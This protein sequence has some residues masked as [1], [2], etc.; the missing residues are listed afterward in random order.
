[1]KIDP[2][3]AA[4][5]IPAVLKDSGATEYEAVPGMT[6]RAYLA[7]TAGDPPVEWLENVMNTTEPFRCGGQELVD[8]IAKWRVMQADAII[9]E[10]NKEPRP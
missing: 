4:F 1:M 6:I 9:A 8:N 10:L 3:G 2:N 7:S 5:P